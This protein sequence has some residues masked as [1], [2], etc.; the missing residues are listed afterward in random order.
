[1][2]DRARPPS[3]QKISGHAQKN[4]DFVRKKLSVTLKGALT[5]ALT[6]ALKGPLRG[7]LRGALRCRSSSASGAFAPLAMHPLV[8]VAGR[9]SSSVVVAVTPRR[10]VSDHHG[11]PGFSQNEGQSQGGV[12]GGQG[13]APDTPAKAAS[14]A[15]Q[16]HEAPSRGR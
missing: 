9:G 16:K 7:A 15:H 14:A 8:S 1:M 3:P 6:G 2:D 10:K 5:G 11:W 4:I 13:G 12:G